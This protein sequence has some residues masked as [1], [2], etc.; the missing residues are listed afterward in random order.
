MAD[1][2][3]RE[4][5]EEHARKAAR[6]AGE[7]PLVHAALAVYFELRHSHDDADGMI[8]AMR[9]LAGALYDHR[10]WRG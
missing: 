9:K 6:G 5:G 7:D 4:Q 1:G 10:G 3:W 2:D 8:T